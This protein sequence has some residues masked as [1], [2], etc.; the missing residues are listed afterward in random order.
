MTHPRRSVDPSNY[1]G[2]TVISGGFR[3][4]NLNGIRSLPHIG[5]GLRRLRSDP[6]DGLPAR[7]DPWFGFLHPGRIVRQ[8]P[9]AGR[10]LNA[11]TLSSDPGR[12]AV[13]IMRFTDNVE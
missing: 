3:I 9:A 2:L 6:L 10:K 4:R 12:A 7:E 11:T 8:R 1:P 5:R 13:T